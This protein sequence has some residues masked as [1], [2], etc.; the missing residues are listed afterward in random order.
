MVY[1]FI[2]YYIILYYPPSASPPPCRPGPPP[3]SRGGG[4][5]RTGAGA[6]KTEAGGTGPPCDGQ[7]PDPPGLQSTG[8]G[9]DSGASRTCFWRLPVRHPR[10]MGAPMHAHTHTHTRTCQ[11]MH[12]GAPNA[13][14]GVPISPVGKVWGRGVIVPFEKL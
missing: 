12:H 11:L 1:Y 14:H 3:E 2:S 6:P 7:A 8:F 10:H 4:A 13:A 9:F 5:P